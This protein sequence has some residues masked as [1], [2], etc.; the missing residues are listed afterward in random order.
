M[1][2]CCDENKS[3]TAPQRAWSELSTQDPF[4]GMGL[5]SN[6]LPAHEGQLFF[7][8]AGQALLSKVFPVVTHFLLTAAHEGRHCCSLSSLQTRKRRPGAAGGF[9]GY[10]LRGRAGFG[11]GGLV[12]EAPAKPPHPTELSEKDDSSP[13]C[14]SKQEGRACLVF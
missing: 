7:P 6:P 12:A 9:A 13:S 4:E 8:A 2:L 11:P 1:S 3:P 5:L 10:R 14:R